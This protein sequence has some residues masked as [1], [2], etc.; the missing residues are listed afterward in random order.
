VTLTMSRKSKTKNI[1]VNGLG[2][3]LMVR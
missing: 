1:T 2:K 3:I